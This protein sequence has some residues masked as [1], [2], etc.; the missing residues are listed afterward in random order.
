MEGCMTSTR[1]KRV[2]LRLAL[3]A[4]FVACVYFA[5]SVRRAYACMT[6][7]VPDTQVQWQVPIDPA[8]VAT[9]PSADTFFTPATGQSFTYFAKNTKLYAIV[10]KPASQVTNACGTFPAVNEGA[11]KWALPGGFRDLAHPVT[12]FASPVPLSVSRSP[13]VGWCQEVIFVATDDGVLFKIDAAN[14]NFLAP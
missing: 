14:G 10:N 2:L 4:T 8:G 1:R 9:L 5:D 6:N 3:A 12:N 7:P 13:G 11:F